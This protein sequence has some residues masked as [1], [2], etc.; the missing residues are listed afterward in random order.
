M[1]RV[2]RNTLVEF[3]AFGRKV[4]GTFRTTSCGRADL[5]R[6]QHDFYHS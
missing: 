3:C 5:S 6:I 4:P 1:P 2:I